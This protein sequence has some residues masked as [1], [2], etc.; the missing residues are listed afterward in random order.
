MGSR[1]KEIIMSEKNV[2]R[3]ECKECPLPCCA[4]VEYMF[5][6]NCS[7][8]NGCLFTDDDEGKCDWKQVETE[9]E[10][11]SMSDG[12]EYN[13]ESAFW[14][15]NELL[16]RSNAQLLD[17]SSKYASFVMASAARE[18]QYRVINIPE[19]D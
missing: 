3:F 8:P 16:N 11:D 5:V 7:P 9:Q 2:A 17:L 14:R 4:D 19:E 13:W 1:I 10:G 15:L 12:Q 6:G 18:R